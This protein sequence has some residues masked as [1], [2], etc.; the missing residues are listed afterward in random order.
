MAFDEFV[1]N[2]TVNLADVTGQAERLRV[3]AD[4]VAA[5][6]GVRAHEIGLFRVDVRNHA[7]TFQWPLSMAKAGHIPLNAINSLV[8]KTANEKL[9]TLDNYFAM[10]RHLFIF[11]H[12]LAE[13]SERIPVQKIMSV[14]ILSE[15]SAVGVIQ[16]SRKALSLPEAGEDFTGTNLA[17]LEKIAGVLGGLQLL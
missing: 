17:E 10:S 14:P 3:V 13:K 9:S 6:F 5:F 7:I 2:I 15:G 4:E 8:A 12:M 1:E 11:E 16:V